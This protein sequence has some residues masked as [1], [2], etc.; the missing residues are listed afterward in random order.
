MSSVKRALRDA[1]RAWYAG[2]G[3]APRILR[4]CDVC[5]EEKWQP[6]G[7]HLRGV[8][9]NARLA[10]GR[11]ADLA[12]TDET[13]QVQLVVQ[14]AHGSRLPNRAERADV[15][16]LVLDEGGLAHEPTRWRP[17][18][19][20]G[21]RT[22]RCRCAQ[23]RA[24]PVDDAF[25]LRVIGCP[26]NLRREESAPVPSYASVIHDCARCGFFVGIGYADAQRR[27]VSLYCDFGASARRR[28]GPT[29]APRPSLPL[30]R[31]TNASSSS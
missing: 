11:R 21:L 17:V 8:S 25:S 3:D 22:W 4:H 30:L 26:L 7:R 20:A 9:V 6:V 18:R 23:A 29:A 14:L 2:R 1:I 16:V 5:G 10:D 19:Q 27:R 24:L 15:P 13:G 12:L 31:E 28:V